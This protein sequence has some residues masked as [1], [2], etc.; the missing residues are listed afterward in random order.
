VKLSTNKTPEVA[1]K[2]RLASIGG[3][4]LAAFAGG[5]SLAFA[6]AGYALA[7]ATS[8]S[9]GIGDQLNKLSGEGMNAGGTAF[10]A[11]CYLAA[12]VCFVLGCLGLV[13]E[14]S[15]A[16]PGNRLYRPWYCR[17]RA[18]RTVRHRR[19]MD[20]QG[21]DH[22]LG[23][24]RDDHH[25][26]RHGELPRRHRRLINRSACRCQPVVWLPA[27]VSPREAR[28]QPHNERSITAR[29][30]ILGNGGTPERGRGGHSACGRDSVRLLSSGIAAA[31][32]FRNRG[33]L[34]CVLGGR[35]IGSAGKI[36]VAACAPQEM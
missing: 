22:R 13:A 26:P 17:P 5:L 34:Q 9:G 29:A 15:A 21:G 14:P 30:P 16:A 20:Q 35:G 6:Y 11:A 32:L 10:G 1:R 7:Q 23:R 36:A 28:H 12:A 19:R 3:R 31:A 24:R 25:H 33:C 8:P 27:E 18:V 4:W 2:R